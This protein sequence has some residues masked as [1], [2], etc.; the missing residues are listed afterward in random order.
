MGEDLTGRSLERAGCFPRGRGG[1]PRRVSWIRAGLV[2]VLGCSAACASS[3]EGSLRSTG[4]PLGDWELT[5]DECHSGE[6]EGFFGVDL[7]DSSRPGRFVRIVKE[8]LAGYAVALPNARDGGHGIIDGR[9]C[10]LYDVRVVGTNTFINDVRALDGHLRL[11][12]RFAGGG[13]VEGSVT[14]ETCH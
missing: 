2:A 12:C 6:L 1:A 10:E 11:R 9:G 7:V 5:P 14:F 8:P 3:A 13:S 4:A